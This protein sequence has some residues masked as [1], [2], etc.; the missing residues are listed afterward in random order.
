MFLLKGVDELEA[1]R[2][3]LENYVKHLNSAGYQ[4]SNVP[5]EA[6]LVKPIL[7]TKK[8][9]EKKLKTIGLKLEK[10]QESCNHGNWIYLGRDSHYNHEQ[11]GLC[12]YVDYKA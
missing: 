8:K 11:C 9:Y 3:K 12:G 1:Q 5:E 6:K 10:I 7:S 4:L 2:V